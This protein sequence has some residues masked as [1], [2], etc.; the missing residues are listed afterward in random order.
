MARHPLPPSMDLIIRAMMELTGG[1]PL[2]AL[3]MAD[4]VLALDGVPHRWRLMAVGVK[5]ACPEEATP[6][7]RMQS[8]M[9]LNSEEWASLLGA[10]VLFPDRARQL[11]AE[12]V[13]IDTSALPGL[14]V[15]TPQDATADVKL[16]PRQLEVLKALDSFDTMAGIAKSMY[17][18]TE[19]VRSTAKELYRR[20]GVH[21]RD[22]AVRM[23][24]AMGII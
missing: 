14:A 8:D 6:E 9:F 2:A 21:D 10:V 1:R 4:Q 20:L 7:A 12:R 24:R 3:R 19:T 13:G 22:S 5:L 18:G 15:D 16:T 17:L 23:G 11:V